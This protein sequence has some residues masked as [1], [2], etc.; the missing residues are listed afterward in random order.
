[1]FICPYLLFWAQQQQA[2][3]PACL[4]HATSAEHVAAA[5]G[6]SRSTG[7]PFAVRSGGHSDRSGASNCPGCI[8]INLAGLNQV[9]AAVDADVVHVG[10]GATWGQ[11]YATLAPLNYATT[12][13]R[14]TSVGV[15]G[16]LL[17]GGLSHFSGTRGWACDGVRSFE[18]VLANGTILRHVT[19]DD[20]GHGQHAD[21]FRAL[22]G[23]G[24]GLAVV[25]R[26]TLDV[27]PH[28]GSMWGGLQVWPQAASSL[29][30]TRAV[31][32]EFV[33]FTREAAPLNPHLALFA[34]LGYS[35]HLPGHFL[36]AAGQYDTESRPQSGVDGEEREEPH[37]FAAFN[38]RVEEQGG[39]AKMVSTTRL[40]TLLE[41]AEELNGSEPPGLRSRFTTATV[42]ADAELLRFM[43]KVFV[44]E[45]ERALA[46]AP[47][48]AQDTNFKPMLGIQPLTRNILAAST[49]RG[50]NAMG[51]DIEDGP[52]II[53]SFGWEWSSKE[54][55]HVVIAG[56]QAV[57][58]RSVLAAQERALYHP[59]KY[60]NYAAEDQ[61]P[62]G[63]YGLRSAELIARVS[64]AYDPDGLF[65]ALVQ[66]A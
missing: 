60:M 57:L 44:E 32:D 20:D 41:L 22:R 21:L 25:T 52:L 11:V 28:Q 12:G 36:W 34:G 16:L 38:A 58:M 15:G 26:F 30:V 29:A 48:L 42:K 27:F 9:Q 14:L 24:G 55:D 31:A 10:A 43:A 40:A 7:C 37:A 18:V 50:G 1:M 64:A 39:V 49:A 56:I 66:Q 23:G 33:A 5:V 2:I 6:I 59:F 51:L 46:K 47:G 19:A 3:I 13:G 61:D 4:V 65:A 17:G 63:S 45:V 62:L 8:T 53:C 54:D 35:A